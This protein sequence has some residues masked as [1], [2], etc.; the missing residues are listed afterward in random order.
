MGFNEYD[1]DHVLKICKVAGVDDF[2]GTQQK[3]MIWKLE[4]VEMDCLAVKNKL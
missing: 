4:S 1:D 2:V 3:V